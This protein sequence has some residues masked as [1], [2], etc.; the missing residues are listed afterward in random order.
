MDLSFIKP[1]SFGLSPSDAALLAAVFTYVWRQFQSTLVGIPDK[2]VSIFRYKIRVKGLAPIS[3]PIAD[4]VE[5]LESLPTTRMLLR[6]RQFMP[7]SQV[8]AEN[9]N[10]AR[11][12][13][14]TVR[15]TDNLDVM[16]DSGTGRMTLGAGRYVMQTAQYGILCIDVIEEETPKGNGSFTFYEA[17]R[18]SNGADLTRT[19]S[20]YGIGNRARAKLQKFMRDAV[21]HYINLS[22]DKR[23]C[24][25]Y[26][27]GDWH[28]TIEIRN[29]SRPL[30]AIFTDNDVANKVHANIKAFL[31]SKNVYTRLSVPYHYGVM[32]YGPPGTG[33]TTLVQAI[34]AALDLPIYVFQFEALMSDGDI[35]RALRAIPPKSIVLFEDTDCSTDVVRARR[36]P[37]EDTHGLRAAECIPVDDYGSSVGS[38]I[39][40]ATLSGLLNSLDGVFAPSDVIYMFTTNNIDALDKGLLR[41]GRIDD[42]YHMG[43][44][45]KSTQIRMAEYLGCPESVVAGLPDQ[46]APCDVQHVA[47]RYLTGSIFEDASTKQL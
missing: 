42:H 41:R 31:E 35:S 8:S 32:L 1:P 46:V 43:H 20:V 13:R 34:A 2:I 14:K 6:P 24:F 29:T 38:I 39:Q 40:T 37:K 28:P 18:Y 30:H 12:T 45:S 36:L 3:V 25:V 11:I 23:N 10:S 7:A 44:I 33:K 4:Y 15:S 26:S 5:H 21:A 22:S 16:I 9:V 17:I 47:L 27:G 19:V